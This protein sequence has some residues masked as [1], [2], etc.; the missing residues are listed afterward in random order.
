MATSSSSPESSLL[1]SGNIQV[2]QSPGDSEGLPSCVG[3][4]GA[5]RGQGTVGEPTPPG[6]QSIR[7]EPASPLLLLPKHSLHEVTD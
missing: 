7:A 3:S 4:G 2:C 5:A 1:S 6:T